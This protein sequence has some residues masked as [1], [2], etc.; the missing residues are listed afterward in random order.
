M[1]EPTDTPATTPVTTV[2]VTT[3]PEPVRPNRVT[4]AA[5][6]VG[7]AAG[8]IFIVAVIFFSGFVLGKSSDG[9]GP[10]RGGHD[11]GTTMFHRGGPPPMG[12]H[13]GG[14]MGPMGPQMQPG[15]GAGNPPTTPARP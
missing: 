12:P 1:S 5:A 6:W 7:I 15:P 9:G 3:A 4:Q 10:H 11:R 2:P 14:P 8:V 13:M